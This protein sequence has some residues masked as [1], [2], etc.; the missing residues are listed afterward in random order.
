[1]DR[2]RF[3]NDINNIGFTVHHDVFDH[4]KIRVLNE[5]A[6]SL[7]PERGHDKNMKW[8]GWNTVSKMKE[9]MHE[10]DWAYYWTPH[11]HHEYIDEIKQHLAPM[12]NAAFGDGN[13]V[14]HVQDFIVLQP[15]MNFMRPH[16]DTPYR[17]KEFR[18]AEGLLG[19]QFMVMMCEFTPDNGATGYV[20][21]SHKYIYDGIH[22]RD[23]QE[24]WRIFFADNYQQYTAGPGSFVCWHPRVL[25]STMPNKTGEV[26]R[27][28]L[29]HAAEK[30]TARRLEAV[31]PQFNYDLRTT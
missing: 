31:D 27:A 22:M 6:S 18:Y 14:W 25:H 1:M 11:V 17:F 10:V 5:Y 8:H 15:G 30:N 29:L 21:G 7:P 26:R 19:L 16:V 3:V 23:K 13:W 24:S 2:E 9:P 12:A 20:P 28:L 4:E